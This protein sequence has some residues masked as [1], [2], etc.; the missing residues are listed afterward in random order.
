M[1][2][3]F[4]PLPGPSH[5]AYYTPSSEHSPTP[6]PRTTP[7]PPTLRILTASSTDPSPSNHESR[8]IEDRSPR[9]SSDSL[10]SE[11][12]QQ[13]LANEVCWN[14]SL[15]SGQLAPLDVDEGR[16]MNGITKGASSRGSQDSEE[17]AAVMGD[18][19]SPEEGG[20]EGLVTGSNEASPSKGFSGWKKRRGSSSPK[21]Q[22][23][24][25]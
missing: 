2:R 7:R 18:R 19:A 15:A 25:V 17:G 8:H 9:L 3:S 6:S 24:C 20:R 1:T 12:S 22:A 11:K 16:G 23:R 10:F 5:A 21:E 4:R 13:R 14:P